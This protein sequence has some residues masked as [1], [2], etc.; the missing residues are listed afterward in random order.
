MSAVSVTVFGD[1]PATCQVCLCAMSQ[2]STSSA[3]LVA[4]LLCCNSTPATALCPHTC[5]DCVLL[6]AP[7][8]VNVCPAPAC[9]TTAVCAKQ[10]TGQRHELLAGPMLYGL[11]HVALTVAAW[12]SSPAAAAGLAALC[13]GDGAAD[14]GGR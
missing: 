6:H 11:A 3:E 4:A 14:I 12:R 13:A 7:N 2:Q 8:V 10:R 5:V 1:L 9:T